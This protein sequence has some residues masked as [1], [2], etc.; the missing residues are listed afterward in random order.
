[1]LD[2]TS[3]IRS[4]IALL[5]DDIGQFNECVGSSNE[6]GSITG[7]YCLGNIFIKSKNEE[8]QQLYETKVKLLFQFENILS[9]NKSHFC[10][11][12]EDN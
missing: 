1:M 9:T 8:L 7:K 2:S 12:S 6:D 11:F 10:L 5:N 3:K 4:G